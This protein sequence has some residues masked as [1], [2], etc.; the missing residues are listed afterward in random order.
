MTE[1]TI[2]EEDRPIAR[3]RF[4]DVVPARIIQHRNIPAPRRKEKPSPGY[5][6]II[7]TLRQNRSFRGLPL[8]VVN[9][10][11]PALRL[12][13]YADEELVHAKYD[14]PTQL[15]CVVKGGLRA[16]SISLEGEE[17]VFMFWGVGSWVGLGGILDG[18]ARALDIRT[19][20]QTVLA[21]IGR[22]DFHILLEKHPI[23]YKHLALQMCAIARA[24][25]AAIEDESTL[26]LQARLAKRIVALADTYGKIHREGT[27][28]ELHLPQQALASLLHVSRA[29]VNKMLVGWKRRGWINMRYGTI[30]VK[31]RA[32]LEGLYAVR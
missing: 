17:S 23:L 32:A 4:D 10:L 5:E 29:T 16:S 2:L 22:R 27:L 18:Q 3:E 6:E 1:N 20:Q 11:V 30:I 21:T 7:R 28:I 25:F 26:P 9:E 8:E 31:K 24:A 19:C 14:E 15:Y 12:R 13:L